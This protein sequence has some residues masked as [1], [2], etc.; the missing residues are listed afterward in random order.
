MGCLSCRYSAIRSGPFAIHTSLERVDVAATCIVDLN[1]SSGGGDGLLQFI[2]LQE[3]IARY[4]HLD[5]VMISQSGRKSAS[6]I[7]HLEADLLIAALGPQVRLV[8]V[9]VHG[10]KT[11][12]A[13]EVTQK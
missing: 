6:S 11:E 5:F 10:F 2:D 8:R 4:S 12:V 7:A 3:S 1:I 9:Q 13:E